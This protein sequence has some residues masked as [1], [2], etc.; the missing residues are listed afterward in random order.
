MSFETTS[1][2]ASSPES[3]MKS[4][5]RASPSP[6]TRVALRDRHHQAQVGLDQRVLRGHVAGLRA[7]RQAHLVLLREKADLSD[8]LQ[9]GADGVVRAALRLGRGQAGADNAALVVEVA[10]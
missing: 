7:A 5:R 9:I 1:S 10:Y 8:V 3:S 2:G 4:A 6:A